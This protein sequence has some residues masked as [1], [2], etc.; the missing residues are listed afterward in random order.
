[1]D[2]AD[3]ERMFR[4]ARALGLEGHRVE[5]HRQALRVRPV[6]ELGKVKNP[7]YERRVGM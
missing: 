4:H 1:M 2:A 5:A 3:S 6:L 7:D